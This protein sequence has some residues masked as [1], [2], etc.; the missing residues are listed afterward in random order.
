[1]IEW[2]QGQYSSHYGF[3]GQRRYFTLNWLGGEKPYGFRTSL[4]GFK[5]DL[6]V[7]DLNEATEL[8]DTIR[9]RMIKNLGGAA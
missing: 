6:R 4:P 1:M 7:V 2:K 9:K 3:I 5:Q 8:A